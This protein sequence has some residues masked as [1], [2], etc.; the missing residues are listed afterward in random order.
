MLI[1][2]LPDQPGRP[3]RIDKK[4]IYYYPPVKIKAGCMYKAPKRLPYI[5]RLEQRDALMMPSYFRLEV[6]NDK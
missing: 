1:T 3:S 5:N 2:G 4:R 6:T